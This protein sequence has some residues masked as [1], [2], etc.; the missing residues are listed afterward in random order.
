[1]LVS[2]LLVSLPKTIKVVGV[3]VIVCILHL[4]RQIRKWAERAEY[5]VPTHLYLHHGII[6]HQNTHAARG[7]R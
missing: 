2:Q 7:G 4:H 6:C 3:T 1:M 5:G